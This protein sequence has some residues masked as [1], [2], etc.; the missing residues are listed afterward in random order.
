MF[1]EVVMSSRESEQRIGSR[2]RMVLIVILSLGAIGLVAG[3]AH[4]AMRSIQLN[5][6]ASFPVDI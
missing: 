6:A 4:A 2:R 5:S 3:A 1:M